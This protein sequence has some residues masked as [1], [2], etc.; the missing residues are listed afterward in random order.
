MAIV[1]EGFG[2]VLTHRAQTVVCPVNTVA[3]MGAGLALA[4][5]NRVRGLNEY[6]KGLCHTGRLTLGNCKIY[7]VPGD[8]EER[9]VLLFPTK[10]HWK[11]SSQLK[12]VEDGLKYLAKNYKELGITELAMIPLGCGL[13]GLDYLKDVRPLMVKYL[14]DLDIDVYLLHR[15]AA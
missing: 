7:E 15:D 4:M 13:G 12:N 1:F 6:Y 14:D 3:V 11:D 10:G 2:N 5:R 9:Q 8:E